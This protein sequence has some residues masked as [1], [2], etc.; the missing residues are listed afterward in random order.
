MENFKII[1][2]KILQ[3]KAPYLIAMDV[4]DFSK[5]E[6]DTPIP[7]ADEQVLSIPSPG[8]EPI[9]G[10]IDTHFDE[11]VYF[12]HLNVVFFVPSKQK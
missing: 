12:S 11:Q 8:N 10:V 3:N 2:F 4:V 5:I 1:T 7:V 9:V 6:L